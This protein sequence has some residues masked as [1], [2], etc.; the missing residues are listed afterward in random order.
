MIYALI[1]VW[2]IHGVPP[3]MEGIVVAIFEKSEHCCEALKAMQPRFALQS[4]AYCVK[5][6]RDRPQET[7]TIIDCGEEP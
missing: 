6:D 4:I 5:G 1:V 7:S 2:F 3:K